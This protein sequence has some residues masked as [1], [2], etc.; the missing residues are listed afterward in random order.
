M[1]G[2]SAKVTRT[3]EQAQAETEK[4][5]DI[6]GITAENIKDIET[7]DYEVLYNACTEA[8]V[9]YGPVVDGDYYPTGT[10]EMSKDIPLMCRKRPGRVLYQLWQPD[11]SGYDSQQKCR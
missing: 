7:I 3:T 11:H 9:N 4:V 5:L 2:G 8:G 10:Y 6:L 1:S